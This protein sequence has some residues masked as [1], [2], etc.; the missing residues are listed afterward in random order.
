MTWSAVVARLSGR[1]EFRDPEQ[2]DKALVVGSGLPI[3]ALV[4]LGLLM[5][6]A[7]EGDWAETPIPAAIGVASVL[8]TWGW[9][10][11]RSFD[12]V[13]H[14][15]AGSMTV[16][17][18]GA[19]LVKGDASYLALLSV[20]PASAAFYAAP[21][22]G[23]LWS[24]AAVV[25]ALITVAGLP[26]LHPDAVWQ[27]A[28]AL[29][30]LAGFVLT[31]LTVAAIAT[32]IQFSRAGTLRRIEEARA[33]AEA[34]SQAKSRFLATIS[35][36]LRTP[37][38]GLLGTLELVQLEELPPQVREHLKV[39]S[40]SGF[41]L[42]ALINDLLDLSRAEA[43]RLELT[44]SPF[45]PRAA[46]EQVVRLHE[47]HATRGALSLSC[48]IGWE[49]ERQLLGD[50]VRLQQVVHNLVGNA[51][52]FTA[53]GSVSVE[54]TLTPGGTPARARLE[55]AV[56]DTGRGMTAAE[57]QLIFAPFTQL[58]VSDARSGSG[59]GLAISR[60]LVEQ[61]GGTLSVQSQPRVGTTFTLSVDLPQTEA[62]PAPTEQTISSQSPLPG[63]VLVVDDNAINRKVA[64][65]LL[66]RL[67][68]SVELAESGQQA[69]DLL[70][71]TPV[72]LVLMDL[73]MPD[74]DGAATTRALRL[75][76]AGGSRTPVIALTASALPEEL[77]SCLAAGMD[78]TLTKPVQLRELRRMLGRWLKAG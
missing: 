2:Q 18:T 76:E 11:W 7:F 65:A 67:G 75:R 34:N 46:I 49:G 73:Q 21:R 1:E 78:A 70:A 16:V 60:A 66:Q 9:V 42:L 36:D 56:R 3:S 29:S 47:A 45:D 26:L 50:P 61:M 33:S 43:G 64:S 71:S 69:L 15:M 57:L 44:E 74:L 53:Q 30:Y 54:A 5:L 12:F 58:K 68:L 55:L 37:L 14:L 27:P 6:Y 51:V 41:T 48:K 17:F 32:A 4:C 52:K 38:N 40:D 20:V 25:F 19:A 72:D 63:R 35:H 24:V 39:M 13:T 77:A 10:R 28:P 62:A 8:A 31:I 59:L 22:V 23:L